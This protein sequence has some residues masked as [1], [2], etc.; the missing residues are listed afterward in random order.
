VDL[1][2]GTL[3]IRRTL[4][5]T[6]SDP[7]FTSPKTPG[8]RRSVKLTGKATQ[9]LERHLERQLGEIDVGSLWS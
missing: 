5:I 8:S 6:K 3:Q 2:D 9:A 1:G 4:A 7:V